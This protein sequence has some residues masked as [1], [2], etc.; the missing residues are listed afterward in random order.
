MK[1]IIYLLPL[2]LLMACSP[3]LTSLNVDPKRPQTVPAE[4]L[5]SNA[6]KNLAD[7]VTSPNVNI[8]VFRLFAQQWTET[9][10]TDEANYDLTTRD[11]PQN[12]WTAMYRDVLKNFRESRTI[13]Q[14]D[15]T[16]QPDVKA[17][18]LAIEDIM[19]VYAYATLVDTFGNIPY[20][21]AL[22]FTNVSPKYDDAKTIYLDLI[23]RL[24]AASAALK[25]NAE[26][27]GEADLIYG[28]DAGHWKTFATTLKFKL[29][30]MLADADPA[31]AKTVVEQTAPNVFKLAADNAVFHYLV[32]PPNTNPVWVNLVQS[33]RKDFVGA[34]TIIDRMNAL[35]D[36][37]LAAYFTKD[38]KGAYSG[39]K[40][41][42]SSNYATF[43]KPGDITIEPTNPAI[44][45]DYSEVEFYLAEAVERGMNVG[46]TAQSHYDK[47]ITAAFDNWGV[48]GATNYLARPAV[49]YRTA[50]GT[51]KEKISTQKWLA[52]Y[53]R[54][55]EAWT[56]WRRL[57][58]PRLN[59]P[60]GK[61]Y[62]DIPVRYIY[63]VGEQN[64]NTKSYNAAATAVGGDK[65]STKLFWD[66]N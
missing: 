44:L 17:N 59:V 11:I 50:T 20:A 23:K 33:G 54:G 24:D 28:G 53:N 48:E 61:T 15:A 51:Y 22:D 27:Y 1:K 26:S 65:V 40:Y 18:R 36:P 8:N 2:S 60:A 31:L 19:E 47:A 64:L 13:H 38:A 52:L 62:A 66:K 43:S 25:V 5:F 41:A 14:A 16:L 58:F 12:F 42:A 35:A 6:Q 55:F 57:D 49:N 29:G 63:P 34:N 30:M 37:R 3:D 4:T 9:T 39:G 45:L 10:Y 32:S 46:G 7:A 21:E 56:E